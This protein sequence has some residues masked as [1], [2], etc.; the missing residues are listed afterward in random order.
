MDCSFGNFTAIPDIPASAVHLRLDH[1][2]LPSVPRGAFS[3]LSKLQSLNLNDNGIRKVEPFAFERLVNLTKLEL[4]KNK[5]QT[6]GHKRFANIPKL[7]FL[8][9]SNN[10]LTYSTNDS[11][12][13]TP[14]LVEVNFE[15]N[16]LPFV[17]LLW[18]QP[19]LRR[20]LLPNNRIKNAT[21]SPCYRNSSKALHISLAQNRRMTYLDNNTFHSLAGVSITGMTLAENNINT[22]MSGTFEVF[23]SV[24]FLSLKNNPVSMVSLNNIADGLKKKGL[25]RLDLSGVFKTDKKFQ[26]GVALFQSKTISKLLLCRNSISFLPNNTFKGFRKVRLLNL[27]KNKLSWFSEESLGGLDNLHQIDLS[28]NAF[29][30]FPKFLPNYIEEIDLQYNQ[31]KL[32][33]TN[34]TGYLC[35]LKKLVLKHNKIETIKLGAFDG[36]ENLHVL[37][38]AQNEIAFL[39]GDVFNSFRNLTRLDL[40]NNKLQRIDLNKRRFESLVSLRYLDLSGNDCVYLREDMFESMVSLKYLHLQR[41]KLGASFAGLYGENL[42]KGVK[43]LEELYL[44]DNDI[45][46]LPGSILK[47]Q[48]SLKTLKIGENK[49]SGWGTNLFKFTTNLQILDI[50][51]NQIGL[52]REV[53]LQHL[54]SLK[55]LNLMDNPFACSCELL[56]FRNWLS[57]TKVRVIKLKSYKC[58]SPNEWQDKPLL[59]F[60]EDKI[61]CTFYSKYVIVGSVSAALFGSLVIV[62]LVYRNRWRLRL[63]IYL[64]SKRG[65]QFIGNMRAHVQQANYGAINNQGFYDAYI[66]CC[67]QE[68]D[69]VLRHLLPGIDNGR[70][71]DDNIFGG[72]FKL[73]YDPRDQEPGKTIF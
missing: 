31:I 61:Q 51:H 34:D 25:V 28:S 41:N 53:D 23:Q 59:E 17:P 43:R 30:S 36:L 26:K 7:Q 69:W 3:K 5:I 40:G 13:G 56:W 12:Y 38:L 8:D 65:R 62:T 10:L 68:Y 58:S 60:T 22:V 6:L 14:E 46:A 66:S 9:L 21:F 49:L 11:F 19:K 29:I 32:I 4:R 18:Y 57:T 27:C 48:I 70:L 24:K 42:F 33:D 55:V 20:L 35:N 63:R 15:A 45:R 1:N 67:D 50:N 54:H 73:Y 44:M 47:D 16:K 2:S 39:P 71:N 52:L 37:D 64:L 72:D